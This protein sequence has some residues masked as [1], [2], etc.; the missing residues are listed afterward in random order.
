MLFYGFGEIGAFDINFLKDLLS[1]NMIKGTVSRR[2]WEILGIG[3]FISALTRGFQFS[4]PPSKYYEFVTDYL[5]YI[6][7][8]LNTYS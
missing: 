8:L 1:E 2:Y 3:E 7:A 5:L 6:K 4:P